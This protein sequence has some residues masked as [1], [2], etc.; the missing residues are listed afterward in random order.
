MRKKY[1]I[2]AVIML[3]FFMSIVASTTTIGAT[4]FPDDDLNEVDIPQRGDGDGRQP[5]LTLRLPQLGPEPGI[6]ISP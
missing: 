5:F 4:G 6:P 1:V 2:I 3:V